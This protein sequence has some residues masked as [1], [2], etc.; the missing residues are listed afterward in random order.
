MS[1]EQDADA[2]RPTIARRRF[3]LGWAASFGLGAVAGVS[4]FRIWNRVGDASKPYGDI[5]E[6]VI[7]DKG[8]RTSISF[9][10]AIQ[11]VIAAGALDPEKLRA[12]T[13][14]GAGFPDWVERALSGPSMESIAFSLNTAPFLLNLLWPL[15][16][17]TKTE[18]NQTSPI[19]SVQLPSFASTGGW[20]LGRAPNGAA[21]FNNVE[22]LHLTDDQ[23]KTVLNI[24]KSV[25][26]P[27]CDNSTFFQDCNH[28][29]AMLGLIELA[30]SEGATVD[31]L[32][33]IA[34]AANSYWF[35]DHYTKTA[36]YMAL[37]E[38]R[39][40][41]DVDPQ[42]ILGPRFSTL[43]GWQSNVLT[44]LRRADYLSATGR[45]GQGACGV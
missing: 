41:R 34:L 25:F 5:L 12:N 31:E 6:Q 17:S 33:R 28:G 18:F 30:A 36:L 11:K 8:I 3:L 42:L 22:S 32:Y 39:R 43:S 38:G 9:G 14:P 27:C 7:P 35:P 20:T 37:F 13:R 44:P 16:L 45:M 15:G 24:A 10:D 40:W 19:N 1:I 23:E 21:Y 2:I 26:R 4:G 29:S